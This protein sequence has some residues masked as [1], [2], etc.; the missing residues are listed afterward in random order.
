MLTRTE[1]EYKFR[2]ARY[3]LPEEYNQELRRARAAIDQHMLQTADTILTDA[4]DKHTREKF[5][6]EG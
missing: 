6:G 3:I 5:G 1:V 4:Q 2:I